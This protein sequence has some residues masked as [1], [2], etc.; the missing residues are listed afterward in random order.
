MD[1]CKFASLRLKLK[2][3]MSA[4]HKAQIKGGPTFQAASKNNHNCSLWL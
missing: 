3:L 1:Y 2:K 4:W